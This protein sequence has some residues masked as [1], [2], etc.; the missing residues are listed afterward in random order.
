MIPN[1]EINL[2]KPDDKLILTS[3]GEWKYTFI[4]HKEGDIFVFSHYGLDRIYLKHNNQISYFSMYIVH[5]CF[6]TTQTL[7][8]NKITKVLNQLL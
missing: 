5:K 1:S 2:L 7:R 3:I 4:H 8:G 6:D